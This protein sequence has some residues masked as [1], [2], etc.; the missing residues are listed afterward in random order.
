MNKGMC[1]IIKKWN[2]SDSE[3]NYKPLIAG[4]LNYSKDEIEYKFNS[5]G[6]RCDEF[7]LPSEFPILFLGCSL[8]EGE[9]LPLNEVWSFYLHKKICE[10]TNKN[11]PF[12]STGKGGTS[13]DYSARCFYDYGQ[14]L[15]PKYVFYL[16]SGIYRREFCFETENYQSWFPKHSELYKPSEHFMLMN[17][18]FS[19]PEFAIYQASRSAMILQSVAE[20][21]DCKIFIFGLNADPHIDEDRKIKLFS[22]YKN[23]DYCP[24]NWLKMKFPSSLDAWKE[25]PDEIKNRPLMA[26]DNSH[27]GALW[28]YNVFNFVWDHVKN[29]IDL[30]TNLS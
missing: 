15:K 21:I 1:P 19:D 29:K 27:P 25:V 18:I 5:E 23:I 2:S 28:Q 17:K 26:R 9:G 6:Y 4:R 20:K 8:T 3:E 12:W 10:I 22:S 11:I 7:T 16:M 13:I 30:E 14:V 24:I